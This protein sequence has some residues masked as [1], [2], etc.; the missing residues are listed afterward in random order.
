MLTRLVFCDARAGQVGQ[1]S[2]EGRGPPVED[3]PLQLEQ[4]PALGAARPSDQFVD[5]LA[6]GVGGGGTAPDVVMPG[7]V[8]QRRVLVR[9]LK[10]DAAN[11]LAGPVR[12]RSSAA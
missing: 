4:S 6:G 2:H 5:R 11:G 12:I 9:A 1:L 8:D 10:A 3:V 7:P